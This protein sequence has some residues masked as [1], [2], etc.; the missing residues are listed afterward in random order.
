MDITLTHWALDH[1]PRESTHLWLLPASQINWFMLVDMQLTLIA[2]LTVTSGFACTLSYSTIK[3]RWV[4]VLSKY[5]HL[6][7]T[8]SRTLPWLISDT[9]GMTCG[10]R[11]FR[12]IYSLRIQEGTSILRRLMFALFQRPSSTSISPF[13]LYPLLSTHSLA[14]NTTTALI[15]PTESA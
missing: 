7:S 10:R 1:G 14:R 9:I 4:A 12:D 3:L 15:N 5:Y 2:F 6:N 13:L 11:Y 8:F